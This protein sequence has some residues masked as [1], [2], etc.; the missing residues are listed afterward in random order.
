M[1]GHPLLLVGHLLLVVVVGHLIVV[2]DHLL[3]LEM[4]GHRQVVVQRPE[5]QSE[6]V[7]VAGIENAV[8]LRRRI[9]VVQTE[10]K[11][12]GIENVA[13]RS[14][15]VQNE[16]AMDGREEVVVRIEN[17][18]EIV[19]QRGIVV[20]QRTSLHDKSQDG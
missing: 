1:V 12:I 9:V 19:V 17:G 2:V 15:L 11:A 4:V 7:V 18:R 13:V 3:L 20:V 14:E 8:V 5:V 6:V 10:D 16:N